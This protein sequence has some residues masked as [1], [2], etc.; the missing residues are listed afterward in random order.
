MEE[1][2][3]SMLSVL[4][5]ILSE[6]RTQTKILNGID[7]ATTQQNATVNAISA[8]V[9]KILTILQKPVPPPIVGIEPVA[10]TEKPK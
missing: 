5:A 9:A 3:A 6:L 8:N 4:Q 2:V 1:N 10:G 7:E